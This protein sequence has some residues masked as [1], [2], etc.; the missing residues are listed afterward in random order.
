MPRAF[1]ETDD[2]RPEAKLRA[3]LLFSEHLHHPPQV[4]ITRIGWRPKRS[5]ELSGRCRKA[6][7][8]V[9]NGGKPKF[10][11]THGYPGTALCGFAPPDRRA[12]ASKSGHTLCYIAAR[13]S[14]S[15]SRLTTLRD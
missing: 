7:L 3:A 6:Q 14:C 5:V 1:I 2:G 4:S 11:L 13:A 12:K 8:R 10:K 9:Q 15:K